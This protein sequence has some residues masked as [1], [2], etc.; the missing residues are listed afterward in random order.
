MLGV[1]KLGL[2]LVEVDVVMAI[3]VNVHSSLSLGTIYK[4]DDI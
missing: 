1:V 4:N 3:T 2:P